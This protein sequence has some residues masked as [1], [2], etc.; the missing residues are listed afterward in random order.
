MP[1]RHED[2][3]WVLIPKAAAGFASNFGLLEGIDGVKPSRRLEILPYT[4]GGLTL[5]GKVDPIDPFNR[6][7]QARAGSDLKMGLGPNLTLDGTVNPDFG[8]VEADPAVVNLTAFETFYD[9]RRPF[10][11]EGSE[12]LTGRGLSFLGR[13]IYFY[14]RRIG[15]SP[16]G[17]ASGDFVKSPLNT[18]IFG[19]AKVTGRLPAGLTIGALAAATP[20][21][22]AQTYDTLTRQ[23]GRAAVEPA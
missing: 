20:R 9:E 1:D 8:Q 5:Q 4:S 17:A 3:Y 18:T 15:S 21:E 12:N 10:F 14:S 7:T 16:H 6:K 22:W 23:F 13:P 11:I 19:A 2:D